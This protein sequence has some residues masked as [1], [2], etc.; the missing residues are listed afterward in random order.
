MQPNGSAAKTVCEISSKAAAEGTPPPAVAKEMQQL[1]GSLAWLTYVIGA[2]V[3]AQ[4]FGYSGGTEEH[5]VD[6]GLC[7]RVLT[8]MQEVNERQMKVGRPLLLFP[9]M[10]PLNMN[11][12]LA[13]NLPHFP[14]TQ[15]RLRGDPH[16]DQ[17]LVYFVSC[18]RRTFLSEQH[19][20]PPPGSRVVRREDSGMGDADTTDTVGVHIDHNVVTLPGGGGGG[21]SRGPSSIIADDGETE[22][23]FI[24]DETGPEFTPATPKQ[25]MFQQVFD[26]INM[27][28]HTDVATLM[29]T[30]LANNLRV[31]HDEPEVIKC[32]LEMW[33]ELS[34]TYSSG[35]LLLSLGAVKYLL[36]NHTEE[37]FR[38]LTVPELGRQRTQFYHSLSRVV[39]LEDAPDR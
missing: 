16:L 18:F 24:D 14:Q 34:Q 8:L 9:P 23:G 27:G 33:E 2:V 17:A 6:A 5:L 31:W 21:G 10:S 25:K 20:M 3:A 35:K 37:H 11:P 7:K 38:F 22:P 15:G 12:C 26:A 28:S 13:F 29:I 32:T 4:S 36:Q 30:K 19:G 39:Y 1:E